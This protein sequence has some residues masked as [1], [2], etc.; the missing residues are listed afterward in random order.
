M[1]NYVGFTLGPDALKTLIGGTGTW[2]MEKIATQYGG[3]LIVGGA[4]TGGILTVDGIVDA[5]ITINNLFKMR[6]AANQAKESCC[7][8]K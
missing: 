3:R 5:T 7:K 4:I 1:S 6:E 8:C 2:A